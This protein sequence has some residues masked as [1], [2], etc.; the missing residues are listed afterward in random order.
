MVVSTGNLLV[1]IKVLS[2]QSQLIWVDNLTVNDP[3]YQPESTISFQINLT[4]TGN[5]EIKRIDVKNVFPQFISFTSGSGNFDPN[6]KTLSFEVSNLKPKEIRT[7]IVVGK[8]APGNQLLVD[9]GIICMINQVTATSTDSGTSQDHTQFCIQKP[10]SAGQKEVLG[11]QTPLS[12]AGLL[13]AAQLTQTPA[14]G[15]ES[16]AIFSLIPTLLLGL[17]L[18]K[19]AYKKIKESVLKYQS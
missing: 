13:P 17:F 7:F 8:V 3:K 19:L 9:T 2:P 10:S 6:T 1:D 14:T 11:T 18:K 15:P 16:L 12:K 5:T 4:N